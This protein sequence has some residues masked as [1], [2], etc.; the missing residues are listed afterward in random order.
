MMPPV[1]ATSDSAMKG[2]GRAKASEAPRCGA[3]T[4]RDANHSEAKAGRPCRKPAGWG[5]THPG[6]GRCKL[7]GGA[8]P[9]GAVKAERERA[10][11]AVELYGLP[12][13]VDPHTALLEELARTAGHVAYLGTVV[14]SLER[15][16]QIGPVG[17][18]QGG[19]PEWKP[20]VWIGMYRD[21]RKHLAAIAKAC[22]DV[23]IEE[24]RVRIA[25]QQGQL[26]AKA[27]EGILKELGV[28]DRP[29]TPKVVR[30]HLQVLEG[31]AA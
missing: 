22:I 15:D 31:G 19:F 12:V 3:K 11:A 13:E 28:Y 8:T 7:H 23:G 26:F 5:T 20:S 6:S 30:Q 25:E 17:G 2:K 10:S 16:Q 9:A 21:E 4:K 14:Q 24:R 29:E 18:A 1:G 27:L